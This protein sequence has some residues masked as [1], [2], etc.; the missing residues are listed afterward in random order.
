LVS[1]GF[2]NFADSLEKRKDFLDTSAA[3]FVVTTSNGLYAE[4]STIP[5]G[6]AW[7]IRVSRDFCTR[8]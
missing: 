4:I 8:S 5:G 1:L 7:M 3:D 2:P 6:A